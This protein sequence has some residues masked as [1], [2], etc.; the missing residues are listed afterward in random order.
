MSDI[1]ALVV[2]SPFIPLVGIVAASIA[3]VPYRT[4]TLGPRMLFAMFAVVIGAMFA[5]FKGLSPVSVNAGFLGACILISLWPLYYVIR[6]R[7]ARTLE[8]AVEIA[9][10]FAGRWRCAAGGPLKELNHHVGSAPEQFAY[11]F[12][13]P[14][15]LGWPALPWARTNEAYLAY[16]KDVL[17]PADGT[18]MRVVDGQPEGSPPRSAPEGE[19]KPAGNHVVIQIE[20]GFLVLAHLKPGS[21]VVKSGQHLRRGD[22]IAS[23]GNSGRSTMP[24]LHIHLQQKPGAGKGKGVPLV[25]RDARGRRAAP[26]TGEFLIA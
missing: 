10:P 16:G 3:I 18:V 25:F 8:G 14:N 17:A 15:A 23:C 22:R 2:A 5:S 1:G 9:P 26:V 4:A 21:V 12:Y 11:D 20:G 13:V 7:A 19:K 24:H 6:A